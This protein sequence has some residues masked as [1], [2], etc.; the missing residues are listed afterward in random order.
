MHWLLISRTYFRQLFGI[1]II[2]V[3]IFVN[4]TTI[5]CIRKLKTRVSSNFETTFG[6]HNNDCAVSIVCKFTPHNDYRRGCFVSGFLSGVI[7]LPVE[8]L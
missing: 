4:K 3:I 7:N 8:R 5:T 1:V 6:Y 2:M